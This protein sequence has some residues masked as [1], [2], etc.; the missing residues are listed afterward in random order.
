MMIREPAVAGRFYPADRAGVLR[1]IAAMRVPEEFPDVPDR[2]VG[3]VVPHAGW[4]FSGE[5]AYAVLSAIH[6]R[7]TPATFVLLGAC[8]RPVIGNALF[9]EGAWRTPL[10][11]V[12][13]DERLAEEI[14]ARGGVGNLVRANPAA[15]E[16]EH[17][18][19]VQLPLIQHLFPDA[20]I[21]PIL[22]P[23]DGRAVALGRLVGEVVRD[24]RADAVCFGSSDLTHY[25]PMYGFTPKGMGEAALRWVRDENDR[26]MLDLIAGLK[27]EEIVPEAR[28][29]LNACGSGAIAATLAA[30]RVL[31]AVKGIV[32]R[33][34]TSFDVMQ[35]QMGRA[36][37]DAAVGYPGVVF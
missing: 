30:V 6:S 31:G 26:R 36:D 33:Y 12:R 37:Y 27:A 1:Q 16:G 15:H 21:V 34:T 11:D 24:R 19:E 32:L 22:V 9:P 23:G 4:L 17:S 13:V 2:P 29:H 28:D 35:E 14:L 25:G 18:I 5:T 10:G 20:R 7:R 8:H 3:G